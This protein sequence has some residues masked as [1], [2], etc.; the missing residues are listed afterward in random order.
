MALGDVLSFTTSGAPIA[1]T[2]AATS[3]A[4]TTATLNAVGNPNGSYATGWFRYSPTKPA[5]CNDTFGI[6]AP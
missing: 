2:A 6:R 1:V 3:V 5:S 4:A